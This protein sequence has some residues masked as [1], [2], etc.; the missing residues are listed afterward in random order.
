[1]PYRPGGQPEELCLVFEG[2][3]QGTDTVIA[4]ASF[5]LYANIENLVLAEGAG[6]IFG[7]GNVLA[8]AITGNASANTIIAGDGN[9]SILGNAGN[10]ILFGQ[11]GADTFVF[12]RG[13]GRD[14]IADFT[15]GT[16]KVQLTGL[17]FGGFAQVLTATTQ[18]GVS[19]VVDFGLTEFVILQ[20]V[21][22]ASLSAADFIL[23]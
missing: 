22:K 9:D 5:Y 2:L 23:A 12:E 20:N 19:C 6:A 18:N 15:P 8:N 1:V 16:D 4:T 17:G 7:V 3:N 11:G 10:D 21:N 13:T 14:V